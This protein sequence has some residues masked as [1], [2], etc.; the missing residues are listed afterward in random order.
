MAFRRFIGDGVEG[1]VV[2]VKIEALHLDTIERAGAAPAENRELVAGLVDG[3]VAIDAFGN[4]ESGAASARGGDE[5]WRG[6][7]AEA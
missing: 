1:A 4:S 3:A 2:G 7:R 6:P 5:L